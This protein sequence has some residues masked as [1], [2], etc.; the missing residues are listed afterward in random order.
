MKEV[1][2]IFMSVVL[3]SMLSFA[4]EINVIK[5]DGG[6]E[7]FSLSE[8][9]SITFS[10]YDSTKIITPINM[11][12][13][14]LITQDKIRIHTKTGTFQLFVPEID[15]IFFDAS[16]TIAYF[17]TNAA[18][19]EFNLSEID[20]ITFASDLDTTVYITYS[21]T[22]VSVVNPLELLGVAVTVS[23]ADVVVTST[24]DMSHINYVL[25][26]STSDGMFKIYSDKKFDL[27]LNGVRIANL[28][29]PAINIQSHKEVTVH[30]EDGT[31][32]V[33]TDG[34]TYAAAPNNED[35]DAAFFSEGQLVF[36]GTGNLEI[37]GRG[38][39]QH[40]I[41]VDDF[42]EINGGNII[43]SS[44]VKDGIHSND[45]FFMH[46]GSVNVTS[47]ADGIDGGEARI[48]ITDGN[49]TI[50]NTDQDRD[51]IKCDSSIYISGGTFNLT[52]EG[53]QSKGLNS[54][55]NIFITGGSFNITTAGG[56]ILEP[57]GSGY[58]PS[59]CTAIKADMDVQIDSC[60]ITIT[61]SGPAGRGISCDGDLIM[62]SGTLQITSSGDGD[63]Y[64]N[65]LGETDAYH[66][67]CINTDRHISINGGDIILNHS[68]D[69]GKGLNSDNQINIGTTTSIPTVDITTTGPAITI[70]TG[71]NAEK[72]ESKSITAD[73]A[74]TILNGDIIISSVDD[75]IK[76][77]F[78]ITIENATININ[79]SVE[80]IEAPN[81]YVNSGTIHVHASDDALNATYGGD[82]HANDGSVLTINGGYIYVTSSQGDA[83]DSNGDFYF[84][85]GTVVAHGPQS[86]VEVGVDVNG[87]F[88]VTGGFMIV[89]AGNSNMLQ[90][91]VQSSTQRAVMLRRNQSLAAGTL[92]HIQTS[93]GTDLLTFAPE[94]TYYSIIFS[95]SQLSA[96]TS[97]QV[98]TGGNSNGTV[99]NGLYSGG[100][101]SGGTLRTTFTLSSMVQTVWF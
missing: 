29:G 42:F 43:V 35:Q 84:N 94:R 99:V 85:G 100:T 96:G 88:K 37:V 74:I 66:G 21:D 48:E 75:G 69:G 93:G 34:L 31:N 3:L 60:N 11:A 28:N 24:I 83:L 20:S 55:E 80:G 56:V 91:P 23:G 45:G 26:G 59:Y 12:K 61:T 67:P 64:I 4:Q 97:Y 32:N 14:L 52:V 2:K 87:V 25:S 33:L 62:N 57:S 49:I 101:Y 5:K 22:S 81:I 65:E 68:G 41:G 79:N 17:Q 58:D 6:V 70:G 15:S 82:S 76:S 53:D 77:K 98:Y 95:S 46:G 72:A 54:N 39:D 9:D 10:L 16:G 19:N 13:L 73:S 30:F 1:I 36:E 47:G 7:Q 27:R 71:P 78:W 92:F 18:M 51:A 38:D 86:N 89:S 50:L 90:A 8:V 44:A 63:T 40:G